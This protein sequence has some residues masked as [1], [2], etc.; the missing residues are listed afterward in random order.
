MRTPARSALFA[1]LLTANPMAMAQLLSFDLNISRDPS[2]FGNPGIAS[3]AIGLSVVDPDDPTIS[4]FRVQTQNNLASATFGRGSSA[5][6]GQFDD[7]A[8]ELAQ[9]LQITLTRQ[10]GKTSTY[11]LELSLSSLTAD[12]LPLVS[13]VYPATGS[14]N[15]PLTPTIRWTA[16]IPA[17]EQQVG[18]LGVNRGGYGAPNVSLAVTDTSHT[19]ATPLIPG[20]GYLFYT[21]YSSDL[22][23]R[24]TSQA[25]TSGPGAESLQFEVQ[26]FTAYSSVTVEFTTAIPEPGDFA[27]V[28]GTL[29]AAVGVCRRRP[30]RGWDIATT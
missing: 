2:P 10:G 3:Y 30:R 20:T 9:P 6:V 1:L 16:P 28:A 5:F 21:S 23:S 17:M 8:A 11:Q 18:F 14:I 7:I 4:D 12:D 24:I 26:S 29:L 19:P 25:L 13:A 22:T 15:V 27:V